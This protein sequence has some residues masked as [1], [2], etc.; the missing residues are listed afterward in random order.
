MWW[1]RRARKAKSLLNASFLLALLLLT[2]CFIPIPIGLLSTSIPATGV[3][4]RGELEPA[5]ILH[6]AFQACARRR[7]A[8]HSSSCV[9]MHDRNHRPQKQ[10]QGAEHQQV[11][12]V[13]GHGRSEQHRLCVR[14]RQLWS[15]DRGTYG[16]ADLGAIGNGDCETRIRAP[17]TKRSTAPAPRRQRKCRTSHGV[18]PH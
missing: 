13:F 6:R 11:P 5:F 12:V 14:G 16:G 8:L 15:N 9:P 3:D 10:G 4:G 17:C 7:K 18:H 1:W 2:S